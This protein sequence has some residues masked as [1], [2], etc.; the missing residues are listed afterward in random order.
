MVS[1]MHGR[2]SVHKLLSFVSL[3]VDS[4]DNNHSM[5]A[6]F[7]DIEKAFDSVSHQELLSKLQSYGFAGESLAWFKGYL[8][9]HYHCVQLDGHI[10][11]EK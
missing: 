6:I 9:D 3:M 10:A 2:S 5:G 11:T 7:L 1:S 8:V 4:I